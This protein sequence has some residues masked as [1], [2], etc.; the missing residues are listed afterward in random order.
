MSQNQ[1]LEDL[2]ENDS[3]VRWITDQADTK[4][5]D[6]WLA[7]MREDP[8]RE[9]LVEQAR[10]LT[11][12]AGLEEPISSEPEHEFRKLEHSLDEVESR[13][14]PVFMGMKQRSGAFYGAVAAGI[15]ILVAVVGFLMK[16]NYNL[17]RADNTDTAE[18]K[19]EF[20]TDYGEKI[21]L[22]LS[23][24]SGI[25]LN[26]NSHLKYYTEVKEGQDIDVWLEG[27][28]YFDIYHYEGSRQRSF[29]VHTPDGTVE[30]LGTKFSVKTTHEGTR[31]V[32][33]KGKIRVRVNGDNASKRSKTEVVMAPG[34]LA[35]FTSGIQEVELAEVNSRVYT[36]WTGDTWVF[37][38]TPLVQVASRIEDTFGVKVKIAPSLQKKKLS[39]SIKSNNLEFLQKALSRVVN[40]QVIKMG[41]T[42]VIGESERDRLN[43]R[44]R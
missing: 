9:R 37:D 21:S 38:E 16:E 5:E 33:E 1:K 20:R 22:D 40:T 15:L 6:L 35:H 34:E 28:A 10:E 43:N 2:L 30:V 41:D 31:T 27:E 14:T 25:V 39:G 26:A 3:F 42:I 23:D 13:S 4:E 19:H 17:S 29:T 24:G 7:W 44:I 11:A 32:L 18:T 8:T 12:V 36:S